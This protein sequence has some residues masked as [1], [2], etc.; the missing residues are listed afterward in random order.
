MRVLAYW[1]SP[2]PKKAVT[3]DCQQERGTQMS[4][5]V[6]GDGLVAQNFTSLNINLGIGSYKY[7]SSLLCILILLQQ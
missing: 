2:L 4:D 1:Q 7:L 5:G 3:G 6:S